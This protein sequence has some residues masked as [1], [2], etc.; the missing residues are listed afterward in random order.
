M[1]IPL[2]L[3]LLVILALAGWFQN[4]W[5]FLLFVAGEVFVAVQLLIFIYTAIR[6]HISVHP[7]SGSVRLSYTAAV[8]ADVNV[9]AFCGRKIK[10]KAVLTLPSGEQKKL[11][12][13]VKSEAALL[14][15]PVPAVSA[16][17]MKLTVRNFSFSDPAGIFFFSKK[18]DQTVE[19]PVTDR[20]I[21]EEKH[22]QF[23]G[24]EIRSFREYRH[25]DE[26]RDI[27]WNISARLGKYH[28]KEYEGGENEE[29][30]YASYETES[31]EAPVSE[32]FKKKKF[33]IHDRKKRNLF[34]I[35]L[36]IVLTLGIVMTYLPQVELLP[37]QYRMNTTEIAI[38]GVIGAV[39]V[40]IILGF[41]ISSAV[42][43]AAA[44][45]IY[46]A[47]N[48]L[49]A[50]D[51]NMISFTLIAILVMF[52]VVAVRVRR[53]TKKASDISHVVNIA[54]AFISIAIGMPVAMRGDFATRQ[55][56]S[57]YEAENSEI[58]R[59]AQLYKV[60]Y[61]VP[62]DGRVG[63][64]LNQFTGETQLIVSYDSMEKPKD[65]LYLRFYTGRNYN[66]GKWEGSDPDALK[67]K[68]IDYAAE[69]FRLSDEQ[70]E[71]RKNSKIDY[72][73]SGIYSFMQ[74][75]NNIFEGFGLYF[76][77]YQVRNASPKGY[78]GSRLS[79]DLS[80][81]TVPLGYGGGPAGSNSN[82]PLYAVVPALYSCTDDVS[83]VLNSY[84]N[85]ARNLRAY[86]ESV[87]ENELE[88]LSTNSFM[89]AVADAYQ[90]NYAK[91]YLNVPR[92]GMDRTRQL[93][94]D[95]PLDDVKEITAYIR[96]ILASHATYS[97]TV[98]DPAGNT[99][100][101]EYF[102][103]NS[104]KGYCEQYAS[105]AC[106]L[107]R[108][109]G[110]PAR[111]VSGYKVTPSDYDDDHT[112]YVPDSSAHAWVEIYLPSTGWLPI[113]MTP[114]TLP[115]NAG[116]E[117]TGYPTD[118]TKM[119]WPEFSEGDLMSIQKEHGWTGRIFR[120]K[121]AENTESSSQGQAAEEQKKSTQQQASADATDN[122]DNDSSTTDEKKS[123][124]TE[125]F[126]RTRTLIIW[127][128]VAVAAVVA[129]LLIR[130]IMEY[131]F[132]HA[133]LGAIADRTDRIIAHRGNFAIPVS[134]GESAELTRYFRLL[135]RF[136]YSGYEGTTEETEWAYHMY[137][138]LVKMLDS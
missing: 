74:Y 112:A 133:G 7:Y 102:L 49:N 20:D 5:L 62:F 32:K 29:I 59:L 25:G 71:R 126:E 78:T 135:D 79:Y 73:N 86:S 137:D 83:W 117:V 66:N 108:L 116:N 11:R 124:V 131:R 109:Y 47:R 80:K 38:T 107:Y 60:N 118:T 130:R 119:I 91:Y 55:M 103:F 125:F 98:R 68:C 13:R 6:S 95:Q 89:A 8:R 23:T 57:I 72:F 16:G 111:Y 43:L 51:E 41:R 121:A 3:E 84:E 88:R 94:E 18:I 138:R 106:I 61:R 48:L 81:V 85:Y 40:F 92:S 64:Q 56:N 100:P 87:D 76:Y 46:V 44:S 9:P 99:D 115:K 132:R 35:L 70:K 27:H 34:A 39:A 104:H 30:T 113:E 50:A 22:S 37:A 97:L 14:S 90:K 69:V 96:Y 120:T 58:E 12:Y 45:S 53:T 63:H 33:V 114:A 127:I 24:N 19:I 65:D 31:L 15:L 129:V 128:I 54:I 134:E 26:K 1:I 67:D 28:V 17:V 21:T 82:S 122:T 2:E 136:R 52:Y 77:S 36:R 4:R 42:M 101:V 110:I 93:V 123:A 75:E 105:A 10:I